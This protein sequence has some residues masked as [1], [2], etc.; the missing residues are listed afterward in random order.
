MKRTTDYQW[1][2]INCALWIPEGMGDGR[3]S[4]QFSFRIQTV[5]ITSTTFISPNGG[6]TGSAVSAI[7]RRVV[8]CSVAAPSVTARSM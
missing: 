1:A 8:A 3:D 7:V 5:A 2:H 6:G 4:F